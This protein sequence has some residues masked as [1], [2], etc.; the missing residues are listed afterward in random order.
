MSPPWVQ[1]LALTAH[2]RQE[3][4]RRLQFIIRDT[5]EGVQTAP[6]RMMG[7]GAESSKRLPW[8][9]ATHG[10]LIRTKDTPVTQEI[11]RESGAPCPISPVTQE[12][13]GALHQEPGLRPDRCFLR[14]TGWKRWP[15]AGTQRGN[16]G[17]NEPSLR[18]TLL[19]AAK[20][21]QKP[22]CNPPLGSGAPVPLQ[23]PPSRLLCEVSEHPG[24]G[25]S[26][27]K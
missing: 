24:A 4:A 2:T 26:H 18:E 12:V 11:P 5:G 1:P 19:L 14:L 3:E 7:F 15:Q 21:P 10:H 13:L 9:G 25:N 20:R 8:P 17:A 27:P 6:V 16:T 23:S 22:A